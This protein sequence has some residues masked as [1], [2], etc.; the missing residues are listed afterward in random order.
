[1]MNEPKTLLEAIRYFAVASAAG[2]ALREDLIKA[3]SS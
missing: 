1:M 2:R 3:A